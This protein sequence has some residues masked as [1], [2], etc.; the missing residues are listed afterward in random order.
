MRSGLQVQR[1]RTDIA[2]A[3][4]GAAPGAVVCWAERAGNA[5]S[6]QRW[7]LDGAA[8]G[9]KIMLLASLDRTNCKARDYRPKA[10]WRWGKR[11]KSPTMVRTQ[12]RFNAC[13]LSAMGSQTCIEESLDLASGPFKQAQKT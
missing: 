11:P 3:V 8:V 6:P 10:A 4:V 9:F 5:L 2:G 12:P 1:L 13:R 7:K